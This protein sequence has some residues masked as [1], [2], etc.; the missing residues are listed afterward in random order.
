MT[1]RVGMV[2]QICDTPG[3]LAC[4][5][6]GQTDSG[7]ILGLAV[8]QSLMQSSLAAVLPH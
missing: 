6:R 8:V 2:G 3:R 1:P 4:P 5:C 7:E